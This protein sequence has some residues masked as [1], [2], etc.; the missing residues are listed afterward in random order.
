MQGGAYTARHGRGMIRSY[1]VLLG[2]LTLSAADT[3]DKSQ[4]SYRCRDR[5]L[6]VQASATVSSYLGSGPVV[7]ART[8]ITPVPVPVGRSALTLYRL[9]VYSSQICVGKLRKQLLVRTTTDIE[10]VGIADRYKWDTST[11]CITCMYL[12]CTR[13]AFFSWAISPTPFFFRPTCLLPRE[14][15]IF[16]ITGDH[17]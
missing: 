7:F 2:A 12:V 3:V 13:I 8:G 5:Y 4:K 15:E 6:G 9:V 17:S 11:R 16:G 10:M 14:V 1:A